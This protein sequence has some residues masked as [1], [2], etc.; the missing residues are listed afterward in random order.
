M[1]PCR[2]PPE[3]EQSTEVP[4]HQ[5]PSADSDLRQ[6]IAEPDLRQEIAELRSR[7]AELE[8]S[9]SRWRLLIEKMNEGF[10]ATDRDNRIYLAN[11]KIVDG[12]GYSHEELEVRYLGDLFDDENRAKLEAQEERRR[13]GVAEPYELVWRARGGQRID[14][15]VSPTSLQD[16][17]GRFAGSFAVVTDVTRAQAQPRRAPQARSADPESTEDGEPRSVGRRNRSRLQQPAGRDPGQ[18]RPGVDG[19]SPE[20]P[21][22]ALIGQIETAALR[23][24]DLTQEMLAY[25]GKGKFL[26]EN[27]D[28]SNLV[29]EM[30]HL[31]QASISKKARVELDF[32]DQLPAIE[33]D[34]TQVRQLVMNLITNASEAL[35]EDS[36]V[37]NIGTGELFAD[38]EYLEST[39]MDDELEPQRYVFLEV[40]DTGAGMDGET[41]AKIFDPFFTTKFT[42]RGLGL[43]AVLGIV[44]GDRGAI[45]VSSE[46]GHGT[47]FQVLFPS[48]RARREPRRWW[49]PRKPP[50]P[51][52]GRCWWRTMKS[53]FAA[54]PRG[55]W[56]RQATAFCWP[57]TGSK[58]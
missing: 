52:P 55:A 40:S 46:P 57:V 25:S 51:V 28:L 33:G 38:R 37:I 6:E 30:A 42:G 31:L 27:I 29:V 44:R 21:V 4:D 12:L 50:L 10:V 1:T 39:Y 17:E 54:S 9:Q 2:I 34:P 32:A 49:S 43:A 20:S 13:L 5:R 7:V 26:T 15:V 53:W 35:G 24:S 36:G 48:C 19:A 41:R 47:S 58:R 18:R 56:N 11:A 14:T 3:A 22:H 45:K 23:A 8:L 16:A